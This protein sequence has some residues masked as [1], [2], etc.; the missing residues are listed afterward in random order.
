MRGM[1]TDDAEK[2]KRWVECWKN[3]GPRLESLRREAI[4]NADTT[5]SLLSLDGAFQSALLHHPPVPT[6]GLVEQQA[7]FKKLAERQADRE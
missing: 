2:L 7:W 5:Q 4:R 3:A 1:E 6:S